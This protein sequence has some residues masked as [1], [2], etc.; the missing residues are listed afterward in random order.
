MDDIKLTDFGFSKQFKIPFR[1]DEENVGSI[2]YMAPE[3][4]ARKTDYS[5]TVDLWAVGCIMFYMMTGRL[6]CPY[7]KQNIEIQR[8][9]SL[10]NQVSIFGIKTFKDCQILTNFSQ[11]NE[12]EQI[13]E[14]YGLQVF[15]FYFFLI[16]D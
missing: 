1:K 9:N 8:F 13:Q 16:K 5:V 10:K 14:S 11:K 3:L 12:L 15:I 7:K 6:L 2:P 4:L